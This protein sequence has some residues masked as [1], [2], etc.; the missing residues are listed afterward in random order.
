MKFVAFFQE[1]YNFIS[2]YQPNSRAFPIFCFQG[3][4]ESTNFVKFYF[5]L[6]NES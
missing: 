1:T 2:V 6:K 3:H 4:P 5:M